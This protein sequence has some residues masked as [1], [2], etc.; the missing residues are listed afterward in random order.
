MTENFTHLHLHTDAS[1]RHELGTV[2]QMMTRA[3]VMGFQQI[4]MTDHG[5]L[6]NAITFSIEAAAAGIKPL[7][8]LEGYVEFDGAI[9]HITLL[10]DGMKG[11]HSLLLLNNKAHGSSFRQPAFTIDDLIKYSNGLVCLTGCIASPRSQ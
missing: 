6:A 10:A 3:K 5:T 11:W 1:I 8:G 4:A 9:G 7:I 2:R